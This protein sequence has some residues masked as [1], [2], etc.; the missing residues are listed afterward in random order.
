MKYDRL[1]LIDENEKPLTENPL[2]DALAAAN[3]G[4]AL[5]DLLEEALQ[6]SLRIPKAL[7]PE[8]EASEV[9]QSHLELDESAIEST[10]KSL[11]VDDVIAKIDEALKMD[12]T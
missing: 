10:G 12:T 3:L 9:G 8:T 1:K 6:E 7:M 4:N 5:Y 2:V 11:S